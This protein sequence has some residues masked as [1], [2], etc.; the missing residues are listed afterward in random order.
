[1]T[2]GSTIGPDDRS[3]TPFR[4]E[5]EPAVVRFGTGCVADLAS[6]L[7]RQGLERALVVCGRTVGSTPAVIDPVRDGL[8][9]RL[10]GV[11]AETTPKK[12]L[13]TAVAAAEACHERDA[14]VVVS[15]GGGSSLDLAKIASAIAGDDRRPEA[16][17][18]E[19]AER[20]TVTVSPDALPV[21][22]IPTTLAGADL[23]QVAGVTATPDEGSD[24][25]P[26]RGG[27]S[28]RHLM[29][30]AVF[31]DPALVATTP[32]R[33]LFASAMNGFD[34]PIETLY[35]S[36]ATPVTDATA[37]RAIQLLAPG[38]R[39]MGTTGV[40]E[41]VL[42]PVLEGIL[43]AQYGIS[44][45]D[46]LT[47]SVVHSFGHALTRHYPIQQGAAHAVVAPHA[48]AFIFD[49]VDGRRGLLAD[50]FGV[51]D[52]GDPAAAIVDEVVAVRDALD[53]PTRLRDVDGPDPGDFQTVARD[54]LDD[55]FMRNAPPTLD[56]TV[57]GLVDVLQAAW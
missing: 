40:D 32:E 50:A 38:L 13:A 21:V 27:V 10:A 48:L 54:T 20:A 12:R 22:A 11:F 44:R 2:P 37:V 31:Y 3:G 25:E 57:D 23:T 39:D 15:L 16:I 14:D 34:K 9:D 7:E 46:A 8:D 1:M 5:Y 56:A 51:T 6:E 49:R 52:A 18:T 42:E 17:A 41:S 28:S 30:D 36:T 26:T 33:V 24:E 55:S 29:P 4:F 43:L 47:M 45:P 35:A 19:F 53:L